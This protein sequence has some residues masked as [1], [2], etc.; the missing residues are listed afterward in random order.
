M[1]TSNNKRT[2][3]GMNS[4]QAK[5][6]TYTTEV[7]ESLSYG[8]R[9]NFGKVISLEKALTMKL[10]RSQAS[11]SYAEKLTYWDR[12]S[13]ARDCLSLAYVS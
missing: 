12:V 3:S 11:K 13:G 2:A 1:K 5:R 4:R 6:V 8:S 10:T 9:V 7:T